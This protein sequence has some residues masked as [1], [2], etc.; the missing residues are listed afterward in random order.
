MNPLFK[1]FGGGKMPPQ[2]QNMQ[3]VMTQFQNFKSSFNGNPQQQVQNL[4]NSGKMSQAQFNQ[5]QQWASM[6]ERMMGK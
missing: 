5:L 6:I 4:L 1:L 3:N 2:M